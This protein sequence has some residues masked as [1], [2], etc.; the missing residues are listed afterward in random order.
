MTTSTNAPST[1]WSSWS[2]STRVFLG[3][4]ALLAVL[5][6]VYLYAT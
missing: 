3:A 6:V 2:T 1:H 5:V 4:G